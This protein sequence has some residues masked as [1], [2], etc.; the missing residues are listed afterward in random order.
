[1]LEIAGPLLDALD[2]GH[3]VAVATVTRV[4]GSAPRTL[5][6]A[7]A[8]TEAGTVVGSISGGC[9]EGEVYALSG[10]VLADGRCVLTEF[11]VTDDDAFAAGL[12]CGGSLEVFVSEL[13][14]AG[15]RN[16]LSAGVRSELEAA[17]RGEPAGLA[18]VVDGPGTG[19]ILPAGAGAAA[20]HDVALDDA[21]AR[22]ITAELRALLAAGATATGELACGAREVRV[23]YV[24]AAP[25]PRLLIFGAVDFAAAL[26]DAATL[27]GYRV[28]VCD[29]RAVFATPERFP[30]AHDVVVQWPADY[31]AATPV[32]SRTVVCVL[33]HDEKFDL[34]LLTVALR[35]G[36]G[37]V[38]AMGSRRTHERR[39]GRL[40]D[41]GVGPDELARLHSPIGLD[42]G[43]STPAETAVSILA[44]VLA[45]RTG[46][47]GAPL[48]RTD[49]PI[50]P[51]RG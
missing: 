22:R 7:M 5:G 20:D 46:A 39:V 36:V 2:S 16:A 34:P 17:R 4:L 30:S 1:M 35:L 40:T 43:A 24:V 12:S 32:D 44:E 8:V 48:A 18:I 11:G 3:R 51:T 25:P 21:T 33:T 14:P 42:L 13:A 38:G 23:L 10:E 19:M 50:H 27:L 31:L 37:Y 6:T 41:A 9:V 45:A 29:A 26:C 49:G 28:T 15:E 47:S